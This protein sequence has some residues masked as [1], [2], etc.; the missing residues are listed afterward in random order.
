MKTSMKAAPQ[1]GTISNQFIEAVR[2]RLIENKR[3]RRTLP[4]WGRLHIDRQL[5][6][7]CVYR[8]PAEPHDDGT[9][10]L[11]VGEASYLLA[12]GERPFQKGLRAL[13]RNIAATQS[14]IFGGFL[15]VEIW[16]A[17]PPRPGDQIEP[18]NRTPRFRIFAPK[19]VGLSPTIERFEKSLK[20]IVT[21]DQSAEVETRLGAAASPPG[22]SALLTPGDI[23]ELGAF[24]IGLEI[25]PI[26]CDAE[27]AQVFPLVLRSFHW[28]LA[29]ALKQG[30]FEFSHS[31]T[32]HSPPHYLAL[33]RRAMVK[34]VW[35]VDTQLAEVSNAFDLLLLSTPTNTDAAFTAFKRSG[36]ESKPEF[37]Y[38]SLPVDPAL[39]KRTLHKIP[40]EKVEDPALTRIFQEKQTEL[41]RKITMLMDRG[42]ARFLYGSLQVFGPVQNDLLRAAKDLLDHIPSRSHEESPR[43]YIDADAFAR[44]AS[45]E[46]EHYRQ[47]SR[48][49]SASIEVR[50]DISGLLVSHGKLLIGKRSK[51]PVSRVQAL[52][53]HEVGTHLLTYFNGRAQP[54]KQLY[55]GLAGYDE[56]QE[57]LAVLSEYFVGGLSRPRMRLL[58]ARVIAARRLIE[59]A[60]FVETFREIDRTY[61]FEKRTAFTITM[62]VYR[63]GGLTKDA[64]YLR[65]L[66]A[67]LQYLKKGGEIEPLFVGKFNRTHIP[68]I[69]E[70]QWRNV[71]HPGIVIPRY[72]SDEGVAEKLRRIRNGA[73]L[74][75][76][77]EKKKAMKGRD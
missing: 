59:G 73:G 7:L 10:R 52:L 8:H 38:R 62:R 69:K 3:V 21:F 20:T 68:I 76:L 12:S 43:A 19:S 41:D 23:K 71:L 6:F 51:I 47:Q 34:A 46:I 61:D 75:D 53:Q 66:I 57:G 32:I 1:N 48:D 63:A 11:L 14:R 60:S 39:L 49:F 65:G 36:F 16:S 33:G 50:G 28:M 18:D 67:L 55:S 31:R 56:L 64:T 35:D 44:A 37:L 26:Y 54:F 40:I 2:S 29:R 77:I 13:V 72:M 30:L 22:Y 27:T 24:M 15:I 5:P 17:S 74:L 45:S 9:E 42:T 58:A 25:K 4:I 70:L